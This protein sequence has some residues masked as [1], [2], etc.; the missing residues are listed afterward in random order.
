MALNKPTYQKFPYIPGDDTYDSGNAVDG[1]KADLTWNGGQCVYSFYEETPTWWVNLTN[2]L[3]IHHITIYFMTGNFP[4]GKVILGTSCLLVW[5]L[6]V[7]S[8]KFIGKQNVQHRLV[9]IC[10]HF[11]ESNTSK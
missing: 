6:F 5:F 3:S 8:Y 2:I 9:D 11:G 1:L 10:A 7:F 4:W